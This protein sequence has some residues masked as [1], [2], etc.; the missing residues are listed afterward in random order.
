MKLHTEQF[1]YYSNEGKRQWNIAP[2]KFTVKI[3]ASSEDIRLQEQ[4]TLTGDVVTKPLRDYYF[5]ECSVT[6]K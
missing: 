4:V 6:G 2:G 3:G 5:S 1:G